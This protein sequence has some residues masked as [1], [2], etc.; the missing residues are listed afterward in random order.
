M[1]IAISCDVLGEENNGTSIATM[2]LVRSLRS[3]GHEVRIICCDQQH[4]G[5]DDYYIVPVRNFGIFNGYVAKNGVTLAKP[6]LHII[7]E[8]LMGV[9][10]VHIMQPFSLGQTVA[11]MA[12]LMGTPISGGFHTQAENFTSHVNLMNNGFVNRFTYQYFYKKLYALCDCIHYPSQFIRD[13]F[14]AI[15]GYTNGYVISN[16]VNENFVKNNAKKP[17]QFGGKFVILFTGRY[18]KEKSHKVLIDAVQKSKYCDKIQLIFAGDGPCRKQLMRYAVR[19]LPIQPIF[20]F[21]SRE[22]LIDVI[23]YADLY[24]HPAEIEI[25]AIACLEAISC[26]TVPVIANSKRC[27]TKA[28]A[29][30][31]NNLFENR[32]SADLADKIDYWIEHPEEKRKCSE[33][34]Q[35]YAKRFDQ[36]QCMDEMETM[37]K[38]TVLYAKKEVNASVKELEI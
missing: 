7:E 12:K 10:I 37:F 8:A 16:G 1:K 24:V 35:G 33:Q 26:G 38:E 3:K 18:S 9:D 21:Y 36:N 5:Q 17:E 19:H 13:T 28:F 27:A 29:I 34:Y 25:E 15:M 2:N 30:S 6:D 14:E 20:K 31:E 4:K 32:N 11:R 22:E 23:N